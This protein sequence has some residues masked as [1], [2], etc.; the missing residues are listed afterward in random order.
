MPH[1]VTDACTG[2]RFTECVSTCPVAC[3][4][5]DDDMLYIN[6]DECID[7]AACIPACPVHAIHPD[8]D[9][10]EGLEHWQEINEEKCKE[11][12]IIKTQQEPLEGALAKKAALGF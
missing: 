4:H 11:L 5:G 6:P 2:C 1:I 3:F 8:F 7:C 12:P 10:P 9:I